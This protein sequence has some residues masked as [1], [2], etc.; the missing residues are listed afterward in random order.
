M[1]VAVAEKPYVLH[2][3]PGRARIHVPEWSGQGKRTIETQLRQVQGIY[4]AQANSLTGNILINFDPAVTN[5]QTILS[6]VGSL[7]LDSINEQ[8]E[9]PF[10]LPPAIQE[11][12]G[13]TIRVRVAMRGLD[14]DPHLAK[15]V[16]ER[17][18]SQPGVHARAN[19][20]TGR[21]LVEFEEPQA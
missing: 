5:E 20:L 4:S 15:R 13:R 10:S 11:K 2:T 17:L 6:A 3:I 19:P 16:V 14:R 1:S 18:E 21:V 7:N 12:Q 8:Q 9:K